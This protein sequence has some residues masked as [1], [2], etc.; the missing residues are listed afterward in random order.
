[1]TKPKPQWQPVPGELLT[2]WAEKIDPKNPW[3]EYPRPQMTRPDW[4]SLNGLWEYAIAARSQPW[5]DKYDGHILVPYPVESALSGVKKPL[6][7]TQRLWYRRT[8]N[9]PKSWQDRRILLHFDAVDW[10]TTVWVND[11]PA[12]SHQGGYTPFT[13]DITPN[14]KLD[15]ENTLVVAVW[16]P[17]DAHWQ[18][19]G[20]QT[21]NRHPVFY[22]PTSGIWQTVWLEPVARVHIE[23]LRIT[24]DLDNG[25]INILPLVD[26]PSGGVLVQ[27]IARFGGK[28]IARSAASAGREISFHIPHTKLWTPD[29]PHLYELEVS[30]LDEKKVLDRVDS[31]FAM[32]KF[33]VDK[34]PQGVTRLMLNNQPVFQYGPLDQGFWPDG[35]Y[36]APCDEAL[37]FDVESMK[38]LGFNM[39]RKHI[40]VE[41]MRWYHYC[42]TLGLIVWQDMPN[43]GKVP[44]YPLM[45]YSVV[46]YKSRL[47][48]D[49]YKRINRQAEASRRNYRRELKE[50]VDTLY[51][52]PSIG[53]WV[54][55]NEGWG[56]FDSAAA[57]AWLK[58]YDPS[59]PVDAASGWWDQGAGDL[60]SWHIY[61][62]RLELPPVEENRAVA[63][64]EIGG[65][66]L[67]LPEHAWQLKGL[68]GYG[69][70]KTKEALTKKY[71]SLLEKELAP[72]VKAGLSAAVYTELT[73]V[74][75]EI[76]G[77]LT[78]DRAEVKMD[79][80]QIVE[81]HKSLIGP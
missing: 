76:N 40:K 26:G 37:R 14:I 54:P 33:S 58:E 32:R 9:I 68:F 36:T 8:F 52:V 13:I 24:P 50:M 20:K 21:L 22:T 29:T 60:K 19:H 25:I 38:R 5:I 75:M 17:T 48:D 47:R 56:Q 57:A 78:Y 70:V 53:L 34:D 31:Y 80:A 59:R 74:E 65:Y 6:L 51:S 73:D 49:N 66:G 18:E 28:D 62:R 44:D 15:G 7:P 12:G 27:A 63:L 41:P 11:Q 81:A 72:L 1:M 23:S 45:M 77:F 67:L 2:R 43:G 55:F 71:L 16:D 3:P 61:Q 42:D 10:E 35:L 69:T 46:F 4:Q 79:E 30:L 39:V 64:S